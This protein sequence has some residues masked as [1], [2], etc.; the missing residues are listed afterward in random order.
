MKRGEQE[1]KQAKDEKEDRVKRH[2][3]EEPDEEN[4]NA[5]L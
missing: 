1:E 5:G 4:L 3:D 2:G